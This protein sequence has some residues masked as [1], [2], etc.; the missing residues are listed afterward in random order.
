[1]SGMTRSSKG[2]SATSVVVAV[3]AKRI[4]SARRRSLVTSTVE[5]ITARTA[6]YPIR[7]CNVA[8]GSMLMRPESEGAFSAVAALDQIG[9]AREET[10]EGKICTTIQMIG[11]RMASA[12]RFEVCLSASMSEEGAKIAAKANVSALRRRSAGHR[13]T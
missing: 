6:R 2:A 10:G 7:L 11:K 1:M 13:E 9:F 8:P 3:S 5:K 12:N 4:N